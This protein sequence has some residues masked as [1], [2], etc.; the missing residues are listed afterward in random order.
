MTEQ[1][2]V[3]FFE[4]A[5][6]IDEVIAQADLDA[7]AVTQAL[8]ETAPTVAET[9]VSGVQENTQLQADLDAA[10][11]AEEDAEAPITKF[12]AINGGHIV[13]AQPIKAFAYDKYGSPASVVLA[14]GTE[15]VRPRTHGFIPS[16]GDYFVQEHVITSL[17]E[18]QAYVE[19]GE[20]AILGKKLFESLYYPV[21]G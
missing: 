3:P 19:Q 2:E 20:T 7:A 17:S 6:K 10:V 8:K 14:D 16:V 11:D 9:P 1:N 21:E 4:Q 18:T 5:D 13:Y 15:K 12:R